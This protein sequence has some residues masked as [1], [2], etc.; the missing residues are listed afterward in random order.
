MINMTEI[1][2]YNELQTEVIIVLLKTFCHWHIDSFGLE[3]NVVGSWNLVTYFSIWQH[4]VF[5]L[6]FVPVISIFQIMRKNRFYYGEPHRLWKEIRQPWNGI[7][8]SLSKNND[9]NL[10]LPHKQLYVQISSMY[11]ISNICFQKPLKCQWQNVL[12][13]TKNTSIDK[14]W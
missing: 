7:L 4:F 8:W 13:N 3:G 1:F 2:S 5:F 11:G 12:S 10:I 14:V 6:N 9:R